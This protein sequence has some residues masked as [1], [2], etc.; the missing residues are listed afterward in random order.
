MGIHR[1]LV[2][3]V[4]LLLESGADVTLLTNY[5][6]T[7]AASQFPGVKWLAVEQQYNIL[8]EQVSLPRLLR[9]RQF[10]LY[11]APAN[12]GIPLV[13]AGRTPCAW[14]LHDVV[15]LRFPQLYL[16][17]RPL[18][19]LPYL[20]WTVSGVL[21]SDMIFTVSDAPPR[22]SIGFAVGGR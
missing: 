4:R 18:Y 22:I 19:A 12:T 16:Y 9:R 7:E 20:I 13:G 11:W 2:Q 21:R 14:T 17:K 3:I 8:W 15:Q 10:D 6:P 1:Y 5:R